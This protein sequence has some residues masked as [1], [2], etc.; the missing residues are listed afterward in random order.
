MLVLCGVLIVA[1]GF[2]S[3]FMGAPRGLEGADRSR[4]NAVQN[5]LSPPPGQFSH[6]MHG[7]KASE[8][9]VKVNQGKA[10][11]AL[12]R[13][14]PRLF[15]HEPDFSIF[16][17]NVE[18]YDTSGMRLSGV[19]HYK[20][21]FSVLR[22]LFSTTMNKAEIS[23]RLIVTDDT[24]RIR[25]HAKLWMRML[26]FG[27]GAEQDVVHFDGVSAYKLDSTGHIKSH[28][29]ENIV[30]TGGDKQATNLGFVWPSTEAPIPVPAR[31]FFRALNTALDLDTTHPLAISGGPVVAP[32][33]VPAMQPRMRTSSPSTSRAPPPKALEGSE[34]SDACRSKETPMERAA[35]ERAEDKAK[36]DLRRS[37]MRDLFEEPDNGPFGLRSLI[38]QTCETNYDCERPMV[39]CDLLVTSVCCK[40]GLM[41]GKAVEPQLRAIPIPIPVDDN[42]KGLP[43]GLGGG[44][45]PKGPDGGP[46]F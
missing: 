33:S 30:L 22:L 13:D 9:A 45:N 42:E 32:P 23:H 5:I 36:E 21:V 16:A 26:H 24:I 43:P 39:C 2:I 44:P 14:Y 17:E 3:P 25:W 34:H 10:I 31:P 20:R 11:D 12:R 27:Q 37:T 18:L 46:Q 41:V 19:S 38:P 28:R 15:T 6:N 7:A 35:R 40:S 1:A 4:M 8:V 29:L